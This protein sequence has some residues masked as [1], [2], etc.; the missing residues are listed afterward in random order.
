[1]YLTSVVLNRS[2]NGSGV[3]MDL[4]W[5]FLQGVHILSLAHHV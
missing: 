5:S 2:D 1:M 3:K 4:F